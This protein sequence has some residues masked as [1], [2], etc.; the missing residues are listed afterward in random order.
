MKILQDTDLM[1]IGINKGKP[2]QD[3][4][5][6][7]LFWLWTNGGRLGAMEF[8]TK[9]HPVGEYIKRNLTAL[10]VEYPDGIWEK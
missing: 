3:V 7:D 2:M 6:H 1:P 10:K 8:Q 4:P 5:A 9:T